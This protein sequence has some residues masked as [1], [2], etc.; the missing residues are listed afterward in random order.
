MRAETTTNYA[1]SWQVVSGSYYC[2]IVDGGLCVTDGAGYYG[3]G[4]TCRVLALRPLVVRTRQYVVETGYDYL[5]VNGVKYKNSGSGPNGVKMAKGAALLWRSDGSTQRS[6]WKVCADRMT[7]TGISQT[8][9]TQ[10]LR[11]THL[12]SPLLAAPHL[13]SPHLTSPH[14]SITQ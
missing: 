1:K 4:E 5:T 6:G 8:L 9:H 3:A 12:T 13:T 10:T 7:T 2:Q 14:P 11:K